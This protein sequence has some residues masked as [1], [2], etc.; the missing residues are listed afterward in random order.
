MVRA[1]LPV[2]GQP[3]GRGVTMEIKILGTDFAPRKPSMLKQA[4]RGRPPLS[5]TQILW[6]LL[7]WRCGLCRRRIF[8]H[9]ACRRCLEGR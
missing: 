7:P 9:L 8:W 4:F 2:A 6:R 3:R 5:L 1:P